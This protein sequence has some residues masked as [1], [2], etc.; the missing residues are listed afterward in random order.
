M[1]WCWEADAAVRD[2]VDMSDPKAWLVHLVLV[3]GFLFLSGLV[4]VWVVIKCAVHVR[5]TACCCKEFQD[6]MDAFGV[7]QETVIDFYIWS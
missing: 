3:L 4:W 6:W 2:D 5:K 7:C 1:V